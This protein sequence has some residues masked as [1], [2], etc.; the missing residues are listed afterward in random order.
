[1]G[2]EYST[3]RQAAYV[4]VRPL[5]ASFRALPFPEEFLV[6][7]LDLCNAGVLKGREPYRRVPTRRFDDLLQGLAADVVVM[8]RPAELD[9]EKDHWLYVP[10]E[11]PDP[12]PDDVLHRLFGVWLSDLRPENEH[13]SKVREVL[14]G[15]EARPS[16]WRDIAISLLDTECSPGG[17]SRP[18]ERQFQLVSDHFVRRVQAL[19]PYDTGAGVLHFHAVAR[20]PR[21]RG[22]EL[23]SQPL[24]FVDRGKEWWFSVRIGITVHTVPFSPHFRVHVHTGLRRWLTRPSAKSGRVW[25]PSDSDTSVYLRP[26]VPWLPGA[27]S[28]D[29]YTVARLTWDRAE[30]RH[31]WRHGDAAGMLR[32][33]SLSRPFPDVD[34]LLTAPTGW[35]GTS[36]TTRALVVHS[37]RTG[38][39][40]VGSGLMSHQRSQLVEWLEQAFT[41]ELERAPDL[42]RGRLAPNA[43]AATRPEHGDL[44]DATARRAA[45]ARASRSSAGT[46]EGKSAL[47]L[48]LLWQTAEMRDTATAE[49]VAL[50][51]LPGDGGAGDLPADVYETGG[52]GHPVILSWHTDELVIRLRCIKFVGGL[53]ESLGVSAMPGPKT[54]ALAEGL[55]T[56]RAAV[57]KFLA[58]DGAST[59]AAPSLALVEIDRRED[60]PTARDDPKFAVRL[61]C[62][63]AGVVTQFTVVPKTARGYNSAKNIGHRARSAW[64]D[65][66]RQL[67]V[68]VVPRHTLGDKVPADL[69]YLGLWMVTRRKDSRTGLSR[70]LAVAVLVRPDRAPTGGAALLGWDGEAHDGVGAWV[71]YSQLM[72]R[73][74]QIAEVAADDFEETSNGKP[75]WSVR[76]RSEQEQRQETSR[77]L[78]KLLYSEEVRRHPT[79]LLC[80]SQNVRGQWPWLQDG[81]MIRDLVRTG[82]APAASLNDSLRVVRIR[83]GEGNE[84]PQWWGTGSPKGVNGLPAGF[85]VPADADRVFYSTT[86]KAGTFKASAVEA[87]KLAPRP[88]RAG[89]RKGMP[90]VDTGVPAWNP[91]L[92][93]IVVQG[94]HPDQGDDP[95][96]LAF[97]VHQQ[98]QA[99]DYTDALRLPLPLHL[100]RLAQ[101]YVLPTASE[102]EDD[103]AER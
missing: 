13:R 70:R 72:L 60:F 51:G 24:P 11:A 39:H 77:F 42:T 75:S 16:R 28:S 31:Q 12:L 32:R 89:P 102:Y 25:L 7:V 68:R 10:S 83:T 33:L 21:G 63:D 69:Q 40:G 43:V 103:H 100:A 37:A 26:V 15:L 91:T 29:R 8:S 55:R 57:A 18:D 96:A 46:G 94:C 52:P 61:G 56:R 97:A 22:A 36:G 54:A 85:W 59:A 6:G 45:L 27:P 48:R 34:Q 3:I 71:P 19:G 76:R 35:L 88:L 87:D 41:P 78:Q 53:A 44:A 66:L 98:R 2:F 62:A 20:G 95:E 67:G 101:E 9:P 50:L 79:V 23:M 90:T 17:T 82:H 5:T 73:L 14:A 4:P 30:R 49:L 84:T 74:T 58:G 80:H 86:E 65:G 92:V 38:E 81:V 99:P 64:E 47:E 93:E 1:M